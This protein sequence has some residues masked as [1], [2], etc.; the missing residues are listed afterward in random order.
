[1]ALPSESASGCCF[2]QLYI[3]TILALQVSLM[4]WLCRASSNWRLCLASVRPYF[5]LSTSAWH[6]PT[7]LGS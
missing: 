3:E 7:L 1:M 6:M 4:D 5:G 2:L